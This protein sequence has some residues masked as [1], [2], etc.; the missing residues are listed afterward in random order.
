MMISFLKE[1]DNII[2]TRTKAR[3]E[4]LL[5]TNF[6]KFLLCIFLVMSILFFDENG[7]MCRYGGEPDHQIALKNIIK[8]CDPRLAIYYNFNPTAVAQILKDSGKVLGAEHMYSDALK[9]FD[10]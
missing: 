3:N 8:N 7:V 10:K 1:K 2:K 9:L 5:K 4:V 6:R